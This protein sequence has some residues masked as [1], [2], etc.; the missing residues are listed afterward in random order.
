MRY[1]WAVVG[2]LVLTAAS[3]IAWVSSSLLML[4][5]ALPGTPK[6]VI[7]SAA[8]GTLLEPFANRIA[9]LLLPEGA[10]QKAE[11]F[12]R[13]MYGR[14]E[15]GDTVLGQSQVAVWQTV[16]YPWGTVLT[17]HDSLGTTLG[18]LG[19]LA[20]VITDIALRQT[21]NAKPTLLIQLPDTPGPLAV[22]GIL[23]ENA[24]RFT[25]NLT[26]NAPK[27]DFHSGELSHEIDELNIAIPSNV[28]T[29]FPKDIVASIQNKIVS[30][31][32]FTRTL[33][34]IV[35][36]FAQ[37]QAFGIR[38]RS[39]DSNMVAI[40][41]VEQE[42]SRKF[43]D[44]LRDWVALERAYISPVERA[45]TLPDGTIGYELI[46]APEVN[47]GFS[48]MGTDGC[49]TSY[50]G[51]RQVWRCR[52]D[53]VVVFGVAYN[54]TRRLLTDLQDLSVAGQWKVV[55]PGMYA[56]TLPKLMGVKDA[57]PVESLT[58]IGHNATVQGLG[59]VVFQ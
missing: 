58:I 17:R 38:A 41:V 30:E 50:I 28:L 19:Q 51:S 42:G 8:A 6:T 29:I 45:F 47:S 54:E 55:L 18:E 46:P 37:A 9:E 15:R 57:R 43:S 56:A 4:Q 33:P 13:W 39:T 48:L 52:E 24:F 20:G 22:S 31:L 44:T 27:P 36:Q 59:R 23:E 10:Q 35:D 21:A 12:S 25:Y 40:G 32:G 11:A 1:I 2:I 7:G 49:Q 14:N 3:A 26:G 34:D 16:I 53:N 5:A